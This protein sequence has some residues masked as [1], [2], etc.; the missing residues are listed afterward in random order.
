MNAPKKVEIIYFTDVL[1]IWAYLAQIRI[2]E[3]KTKFGLSVEITNH[4]IP[5]FGSVESKMKQNWGNAGGVSSYSAHVKEI[6]QKFGH[7]DIHPEIWVKNRPAT[8][9]SCHLFLKAIQILQQHDDL[10][11]ISK[12]DDSYKNTFE[13]IVWELR[14][15]FFRDLI[16]ISNFNAQM[17]MAERLE[18]PLH[19]IESLIRTGAAFAALDEDLQLKEQYGITGS[20]TLVLNEGRQIIYGNVGY[21]VIEA[22]VQ[23]LLSQPENHASWC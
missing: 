16:D 22:N 23:E 10:P 15:A 2:D 18:L 21:R 14:L 7:I 3:L 20:P 8:S 5:V 11:D 4:F 1:C 12:S 6:A 17:E 13:N 19:K 9:T